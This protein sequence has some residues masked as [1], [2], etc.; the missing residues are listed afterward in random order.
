MLREL[1]QNELATVSGAG[2]IVTVYPEI[3][4]GYEIV[5]WT[6][7]IVGWDSFSWIENVGLFT[8][9]EHIQQLP[10]LDIQPIYAPIV[11]TT[12]TYYY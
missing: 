6:Q 5:G 7:E 10:I 11:V 3:P 8:T 12:T 4:Y 9:I 1:T 2:D